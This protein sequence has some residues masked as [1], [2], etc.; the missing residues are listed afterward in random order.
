MGDLKKHVS[1]C[2]RSESSSESKYTSF[3][4]VNLANL[5]LGI[6]IFC[7]NNLD[8]FVSFLSLF[9]VFCSLTGY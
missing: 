8:I 2:K 6:L 3:L 1:L 4:N 7:K 5:C 9:E